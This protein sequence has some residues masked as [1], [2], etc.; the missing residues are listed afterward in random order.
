MNVEKVK[1]VQQEVEYRPFEGAQKSRCSTR[2]F[3][4]LHVMFKANLQR[5]T[6]MI[7]VNHQTKTYAR[8]KLLD[9]TG[10]YTYG[11]LIYYR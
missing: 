2:L 6:T 7:E 4:L 3:I 1:S 10:A 11:D 9:V 8:N 5:K